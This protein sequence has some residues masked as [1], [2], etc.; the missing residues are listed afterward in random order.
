MNE[1]EL[2][3]DDEENDVTEEQQIDYDKLKNPAIIEEQIV[4]DEVPVE[5][6]V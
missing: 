3:E 6:K 1:A 4:E 5:S 2:V